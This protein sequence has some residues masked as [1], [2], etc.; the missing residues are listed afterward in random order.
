MYKL[1]ILGILVTHMNPLFW[2]ILGIS[3]FDLLAVLS[4]KYYSLNKN[5]WLLIASS[6]LFAITALFF[7]RSLQYE[8]LAIV[9]VFWTSISVVLIT[10][11]GVFLFKE[12]ITILQFVGIVFTVLGLILIEIK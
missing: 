3:F 6:M 12:H 2:N 11:F 1:N 7:A 5:V 9:N 4:A 8:N 10:I